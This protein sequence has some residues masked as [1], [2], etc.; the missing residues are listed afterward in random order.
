MVAWIL[1][2]MLVLQPV[3]PWSE[4]YESSAAVIAA[5]STTHPMKGDKNG[6]YT[7]VVLVSVAWFESRFNPE[8]HNPKDPGGGSYGLYQASRVPIPEVATQTAQALEMIKQSF[9]VCA[10]LPLEKRLS[11]YTSGG[12]VCFPTKE[13]T[14]RMQLAM[15]LL[16]EHPAP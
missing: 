16:K 7:A 12:P 5:E 14:H 6:N 10:G 15:K 3:A 11:W 2:L 13:S 9:R 4:T 1:A 8:A